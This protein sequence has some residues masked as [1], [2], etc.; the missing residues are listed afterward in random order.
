[1]NESQPPSSATTREVIEQ[2]ADAMRADDGGTRPAPGAGTHDWSFD[3]PA[4][5]PASPAYAPAGRSTHPSAAPAPYGAPPIRA[6]ARVPGLVWALIGGAG[7]LVLALVIAGVFGSVL[8]PVT[9]DDAVPPVQPYPEVTDE[10][11]EPPSDIYDMPTPPGIDDVPAEVDGWTASSVGDS[12][13]RYQAASSPGTIYVHGLGRAMSIDE[14]AVIFGD[15]A[16]T[17]AEGRVVCGTRGP[18]A[19]CFVATGDF[20]IVEVSADDSSVPPD[21]VTN[22]AFEISDRHP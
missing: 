6:S 4:L 14:W 8:V 21:T 7:V 9:S 19:T 5:P 12:Y 20:G 2:P 3:A 1:M 11:V 15:S 13:V 18:D 16:A 10:V 17:H 22:I